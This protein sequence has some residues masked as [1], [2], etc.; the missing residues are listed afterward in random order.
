VIKS[1]ITT[2]V[3]GFTNKQAPSSKEIS[4]GSGNT[5]SELY[6]PNSAQVYA[7]TEILYPGL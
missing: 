6:N 3:R 2:T 4:S 7:Q 1:T 5:A